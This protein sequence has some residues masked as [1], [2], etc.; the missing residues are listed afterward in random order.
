MIRP[1]GQVNK[2]LSGKGSQ[3]CVSGSGIFVSRRHIIL[4]AF[5]FILL[6]DL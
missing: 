5:D 6:E 4:T 3:N 1:S 2:K